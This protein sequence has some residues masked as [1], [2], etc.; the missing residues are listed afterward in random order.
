[1]RKWFGMR[2]QLR[3]RELKGRYRILIDPGFSKSVFYEL[4]PVRKPKLPR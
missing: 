3:H 1:M 4:M 2:E